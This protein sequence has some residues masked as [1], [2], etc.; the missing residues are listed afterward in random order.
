[1]PLGSPAAQ[2]AWGGGALIDTNDLLKLA[3]VA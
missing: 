2:Q 3:D 1:M